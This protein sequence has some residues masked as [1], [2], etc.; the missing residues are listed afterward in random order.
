MT[1]G[2]GAQTMFKVQAE[3]VVLLLKDQNSAELKRSWRK[4]VT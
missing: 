3:L 2:W 1:W 4:A